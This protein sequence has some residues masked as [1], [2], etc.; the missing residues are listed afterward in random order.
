MDKVCEA[1]ENCNLISFVKRTSANNRVK[2][3]IQQAPG[4]EVG[5]DVP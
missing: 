1:I 4:E 2:K 5:G 3:V